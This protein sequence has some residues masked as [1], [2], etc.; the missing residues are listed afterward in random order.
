MRSVIIHKI[1]VIT[2][3][4]YVSESAGDE[5]PLAGRTRITVTEG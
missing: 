5:M 2:A 3:A 1:V 4:G